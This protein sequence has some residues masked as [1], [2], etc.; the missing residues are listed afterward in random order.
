MICCMD[1]C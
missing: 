1:Y